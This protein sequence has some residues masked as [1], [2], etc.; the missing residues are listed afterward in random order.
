MQQVCQ[1]GMVIQDPPGAEVSQ[2]FRV[3]LVGQVHLIISNL[4]LS[5]WQFLF[6]VHWILFRFT[7][8]TWTTGFART[9]RTSWS[10][11]SLWSC[12]WKGTTRWAWTLWKPWISRTSWS[13]WTSWWTWSCRSGWSGWS[14]RF[15]GSCR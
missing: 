14:S 4:L 13:N 10:P 7:W 12:R 5:E 2:G 6:T 11:R 1:V 9:S 3:L 8:W 15:P